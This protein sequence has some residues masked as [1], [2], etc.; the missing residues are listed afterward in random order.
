MAEKT[1]GAN[2]YRAIKGSG[3]GSGA[4]GAGLLVCFLSFFF[5]IFF[6]FNFFF[7]DSENNQ[8][9]MCPLVRYKALKWIGSQ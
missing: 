1:A 9:C 8:I 5:L 4:S 3:D 2:I 6:F 7:E